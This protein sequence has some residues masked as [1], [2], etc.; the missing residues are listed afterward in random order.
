MLMLNTGNFEELS[1]EGTLE[2]F[3]S[4]LPRTINHVIDFVEAMGERYLWIDGLCLVQDDHDD[5][6][7][8][9][10]MMNSIYH[11]AYGTIVAASGVDANAGLNTDHEAKQIV[12]E[13]APGLDMTILHS[14]DWHLNRSQY[15]TRGWTLQ[16]LVLSRRAIVFVDGQVHLRCRTANWSED[17]CSDKWGHWQD[18]HDSNITRIPGLLDGLLAHL[19]PY[20]KL[21]EEYS[22]RNLRREGDALRATAGITRSLAAGMRTLVVE[23]LPGYYLDHF[24]LF[25]SSNG[26]LE[27]RPD[28]GSFSWAGWSGRIMWARGNFAWYDGSERTWD[29]ANI[30]KYFKHNRVV[31]WGSVSSSASHETLSSSTWSYK[32]QSEPSPLLRLMQEYSTV[33]GDVST[34][35][36]KTHDDQRWHSSSGSH[37]DVPE[38]DGPNNELVDARTGF[39]IKAYNMMNGQAEFDRMVRHVEENHERSALM[40]WSAGRS[41]RKLSYQCRSVVNASTNAALAGVR[42]AL[43]GRSK[44]GPRP[45]YRKSEASQFTVRGA[46]ADDQKKVDRRRTLAEERMEAEQVPYVYTLCT[47]NWPQEADIGQQKLSSL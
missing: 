42:Q 20:Q 47:S 28:F 22:R 31:K 45:T 30:L 15:N 14:I 6:A 5:V 8:G 23:G 10:Q 46:D 34:E 17:S 1:M 13:I 44:Y 25:I 11:G 12:M 36:T 35:P 9:I 16:E 39:P 2:T 33:F 38:W 32:D 41:V 18:P 27:R 19:W 3:R 43:E 26:D 24:I 29:V 40:N 21:C 4:R 7:L 37:A